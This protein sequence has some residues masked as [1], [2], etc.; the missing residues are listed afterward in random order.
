[1]SKI[2]LCALIAAT[3]AALAACAPTIKPEQ[4]MASVKPGMTQSEV[5]KRLGPPD[6]GYEAN[7]LECFQYDLGKYYLDSSG[8]VPFAVYFDRSL[9]VAGTT[10][11]MCQG[12]R[13]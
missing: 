6:R 5:Y 3:L 13:V 10:R 12:R 4:V 7:G 1:V 11:G 8:N 9:Q 2:S